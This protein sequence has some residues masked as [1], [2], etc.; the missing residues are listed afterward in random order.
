MSS[1]L[2]EQTWAMR[3]VEEYI[4]RQLEAGLIPTASDINR[5]VI[6]GG[7]WTTKPN[8]INGRYSALRIRIFQEWG[9]VKVGPRLGGSDTQFSGRWRFPDGR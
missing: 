4:K 2:S 5:S 3:R 7:R 9:L 8:S 6:A 1:P